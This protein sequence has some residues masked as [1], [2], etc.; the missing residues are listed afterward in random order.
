M[1][2]LYVEFMDDIYNHV[3]KNMVVIYH[4][5]IIMYDTCIFYIKRATLVLISGLLFVEHW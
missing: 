4:R 5:I 2:Y 1:K 3:S